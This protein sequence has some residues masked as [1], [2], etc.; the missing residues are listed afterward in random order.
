MCFLSLG[1]ID[2]YDE[3]SRCHR[4][5]YEDEEWEFVN[6]AIEPVGFGSEQGFSLP[7]V[8]KRRK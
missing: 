7:T 5:M 1:V 3:A 4:V 8:G 2:A 6:L